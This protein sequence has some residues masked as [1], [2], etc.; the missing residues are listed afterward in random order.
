MASSHSLYLHPYLID[1]P[2]EISPRF[3]V[4]SKHQPIGH[5]FALSALVC[6][7]HWTPGPGRSLPVH[8]AC[9]PDPAFTY[10]AHQI[11]NPPRALF[12]ASSPFTHSRGL[13]PGPGFCPSQPTGS[14]TLT[15]LYLSWIQPL[16]H[17]TL[18]YQGGVSPR[19]PA[20]G[21]PATPSLQS[22]HNSNPKS[23]I[24]R[25]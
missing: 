10:T 7:T 4:P 3:P 21:F 2:Q 19:H 12:W 5:P 8:W 23:Y 25:N 11:L 16:N 1:L 24:V 22:E 14:Q 15:G 13:W 9:V 17:L 18:P 20:C 6:S